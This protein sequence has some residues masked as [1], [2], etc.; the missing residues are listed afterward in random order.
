M[1]HRVR[2]KSRHVA[3]NVFA[4]AIGWTKKYMVS[5]KV[6]HREVPPNV[7][8]TVNSAVNPLHRLLVYAM[9]NRIACPHYPYV[10]I[11]LCAK[12]AQITLLVVGPCFVVFGRTHYK[13]RYVLMSVD[14]V[15]V[16]IVQQFGLF[17]GLSAFSPDVIKENGE[18]AYAKSVHHLKFV[19]K[20][21]AVFVVPLY[22]HSWVNCPIEV[23][24]I[25]L[26]YLV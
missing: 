7:S 26:G 3:C 25:L 6:A 20:I 2:Y 12:C 14:E 24:T 1:F 21:V 22:V 16:N 5:N 8:L 13:R 17:V 15:V 19:D 10:L 4:V 9:H 18:R 11:H 23:Y